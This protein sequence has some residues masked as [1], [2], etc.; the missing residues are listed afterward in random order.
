M[1]ISRRQ[2]L[3]RSG[4]VAAGGLLGRSLFGS[5]FAGSALAQTIGDRYFVVLFLDGGNDGL[6]T[7]TPIANGAQG[8]IR[9]AYENARRSG[10]GGLRLASSALLDA[11]M[12]DAPTGTP[13]G[14]HPGLAG[15][16]NLYS[17]G[18]VAVIQG[19][20]YPE[21]NLSHDE[22]RRIWE[23]AR[24]YGGSAGWV[25][26]YL[27]AN[28]GGADIPAVNI[29]SW[30]S[31]DFAN[32]A[33][34][35][36][37]VERLDRFDFPYGASG[38]ERTAR[39]AALL[40]LCAEASSSGLETLEYIGNNTRATIVASDSY[41][42]LHG[43]Y[44]ADR[45]GWNDNYDAL[46]TETAQNLREVAKILYGVRNGVPNVNAR[47]FQLRNTGYDTHSDQG[48][49]QPDGQHTQLHREVGDALELFYADCADMGLANKVLVLV[50]S[51]FSRRVLQNENGT[52]HGSQGPVFVIG[53]A[54]NGGVYGS[55]PDIREASLEDGNSPYSQAGTFGVTPYRST[56]FRDVYGT[57][58]RRWLGMPAPQVAAL[59][60][61]DT[62]DPATR[63]TSPNFNLGFV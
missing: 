21:P 33:T 9:A 38:S 6:N 15:L 45:P 4:F 44:V 27:A 57:I 35:V 43:L 54:V 49:A 51:E 32:D 42:P 24:L 48:G 52:D 16:K 36:L 40:G 30:I 60:P 62:G 28:Y 22:S 12:V 10:S 61:A 18:K 46:G 3:T 55:H 5:V 53:G 23:T 59:L 31:G 50:W 41:P 47:L 13:I 8:G 29:Q 19:C 39:R 2:F 56:D 37:T 7:I 34:S 58:L 26:R 63:W 1:S 17:L 20:G 25:G 11:G 14:F